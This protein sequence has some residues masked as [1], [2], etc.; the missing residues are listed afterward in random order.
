MSS[1]QRT[2]PAL[3]AFL[4]ATGLAAGLSVPVPALAQGYGGTVS[5]FLVRADSLLAQERIN[6]AIVQYQ[7]ARTLCPT[8]GEIVASLQGEARAHIAI[9]EFLPAAGLLE[10]AAQRFPDD[11]RM[12]DILYLAGFARRQ[13]G[14]VKGALPL[15]EKALEH[16]PT[17]DLLPGLK[18]Q[19]AQAFRLTGQAEK[20]TPLVIDFETEFPNHHLIPNALYTAAIA[21]HDSGDLDKSETVYLHLIQTYPRTQAALE[22]LYELGV[23]LAERGKRSE[24]GEFFRRYAN[25]NPS[26]PIAARAMERAADMTLLRSPSEAA[27]YY[28]VAQVKAQSNPAPPSPD[29]AVSS[30]LGTKRA[31]A[32]GLSRV[33]VLAVLA[34]VLIAI[35][36]G[37]M[38]LVLR[39]W[40][41]RGAGQPDQALSA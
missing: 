16:H 11:P 7:E 39:R 9:K 4:I 14:D 32:D 13:G 6:E 20:A 10:E 23:V 40:R 34:G 38:W 29:L 36:A 19:L 27:L 22:G 26:S 12:A 31:I 18:H 3:A 17:P 2:R 33:W 41:R 1:N 30:W 5:D 15:L 37:V 28:G 24:A 8:P 25:G 21:L 35:L